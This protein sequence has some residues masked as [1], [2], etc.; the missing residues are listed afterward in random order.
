MNIVDKIRDRFPIAPEESDVPHTNGETTRDAR[1]IKA[2]VYL[3]AQTT[4][5]YV[6][7]IELQKARISRY[8]DCLGQKTGTIL[9]FGSDDIYVDLD[10][11]APSALERLGSKLKD[12][13]YPVLL[14]DIDFNEAPKNLLSTLQFLCKPHSRLLNAYTDDDSAVRDAAANRYGPDILT[15]RP[16]G[17]YGDLFDDPSDMVTFFPEVCSQVIDHLFRDQEYRSDQHYQFVRQATNSLCE[18][19]VHRKETKPFLAQKWVSL[20]WQ[21]RRERDE[22]E[23]ELRRKT[24]PLFCHGP[25]GKSTVELFGSGGSALERNEQ[26]LTELG[27]AKK[28]DGKVITYERDLNG[29]TIYADPRRQGGI[30]FYWYPPIAPKKWPQVARW[31]LPYHY[32]N[33]LKQKFESN[34]RREIE[35]VESRS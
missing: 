29:K 6:R 32:K 33:D 19:R 12:G 20:S 8:A 28:S 2:A 11:D 16:R 35:A 5:E 23:L 14:V 22:K 30:E 13:V 1:V 17:V 24:E 7:F 21:L 4:Y 9:S 3:V 26:R 18:S 31:T 34:M 25:E 15:V 10:A 27:F